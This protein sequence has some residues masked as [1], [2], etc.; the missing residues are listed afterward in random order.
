M[1]KLLV[2]ALAA[3]AVIGAAD[4]QVR[5]DTTPV[6]TG[7]CGVLAGH[8]YAVQL[9]G[10]L[11]E[12]PGMHVVTGVWTFAAGS[13]SG[14]D[15]YIMAPVSGVQQR[16][17][18]IECGGGGDDGAMSLTISNAAS[19]TLNANGTY[20]IAIADGGRRFAVSNSGAGGLRFAG[21][22]ERR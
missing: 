20:Y 16:R 5:R 10:Q 9:T 15:H 11:N 13:G 6:Q 2:A 21:W 19:G 12:S 1:K 18:D 4:A 8:S 22:A 7:A 17:Y 3:V 14:S